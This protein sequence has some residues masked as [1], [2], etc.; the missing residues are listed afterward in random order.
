MKYKLEEIK[1]QADYCLNCKTKPCKIG[2]PLQN[3]IPDFIHQI[4]E[5][6]YEKA[7]EILIPKVFSYNMPVITIKFYLL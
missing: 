7:Y 1:K 6:N 4:K 5:E 2:C 3:N